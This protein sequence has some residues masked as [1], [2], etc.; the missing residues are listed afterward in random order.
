MMNMHLMNRSGLA[1]IAAATAFLATPALAQ[2]EAPVAADPAPIVADTPLPADAAPT[3]AA[4]SDVVAPTAR[5]SRTVKAVKT[6]RVVH[7]AAVAPTP[8]S[9]R[10]VTPVAAAPVAIAPATAP[11]AAP[12]DPAMVAPLPDPVAAAP[13]AP[14]ADNGMTDMLPI[15]GAAGLGL[16]ALAGAG[17]AIRRRRRD[18]ELVA[19]ENW[20]EPANSAAAPMVE[21]PMVEAPM[22]DAPIATAP[23]VAGPIA[24]T[25]IA[26]SAFAWEDKASMPA[27]PSAASDLSR[28]EA[29]KRGPTPDNPSASL[30]KRLARAAFFDQRDRLVAAGKAAPVDA[31]AGLPEAMDPVEPQ[32]QPVRRARPPLGM[33]FNRRVQP[34]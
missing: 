5:A 25:P 30:K 28:I 20:V 12:A 2:D 26:A 6:T 33:S 31:M 29:A 22:A 15:A 23:I 9:T 11:V 32:Q 13:I 4:T 24:A 14:V 17:M 3:P 10:S 7:T 1:A 19:E 34:A 18:D 21:A 8:K 27:A 16:L